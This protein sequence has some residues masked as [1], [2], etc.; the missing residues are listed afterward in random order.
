MRKYHLLF[1]VCFVCLL[2]LAGCQKDQSLPVNELPSPSATMQVITNTPTPQPTQ[3]PPA[4]SPTDT[5]IPT[6][7]IL[8][9]A[10]TPTVEVTAPP[11]A[12]TPTSQVPA[13]EATAETP[14]ASDCLDEAAFFADATIPDDTLFE[15]GESMTKVWQVKNTGT[16]TWDNGYTLVFA[17]GDLMNG[18]MSN[19]IP[20]IPPG[21][22]ADVSVNLVAPSR[23][24]QQTGYWEFQN[25]KGTRFGVG[26]GG[27]DYIW[28]QIQV[29][30][31]TTEEEPSATEEPADQP[32]GGGGG[33]G[34]GNSDC[35]AVE[36]P[37]YENQVLALINSARESA[38]LSGLTLNEQLSAAALEHSRD[39]ACVDYIDH[40]G[41]DGSTWYDRVAAQGYAN[42]SSARE[43]IY[44]G[45][46]SYGGTPDGAFTWWMNSQ[47]HRDN[48]LFADVSEI[49][50][51]YVFNPDSSYGGYY[52]VVFARP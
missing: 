6:T 24:G 3:P 10:S 11:E 7:E 32:G 18:P 26:S 44:V 31:P 23:G 2:L 39:M 25:S 38:G 21:E 42:Y 46:P 51:G 8:V 40:T 37:G 28:V 14:E 48:I 34:G 33:G 43:N 15:V 45:D 20:V 16:C 35:K 41:S 19:P 30:W 22:I 29:D 12:A 5:S 17:K 13:T 27:H 1:A 9:V 49:G 4:S 50:I 36:K 52:T 47:V